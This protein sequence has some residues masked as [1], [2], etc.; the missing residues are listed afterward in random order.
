MGVTTTV[1]TSANHNYVIGQNIRLIIPSAYGSF[2]LN[3]QEGF[4]ISIPAV[5]QIELSINSQGFDSFIASPYIATITGATQTTPCVLTCS[6]SFVPGQYV[7]INNVSGMTELNDNAWRVIS[8]NATTLTVDASASIFTAY[9]G[10]GTAELTNHS[11]TQPQTLAIG[12][13][14]S[15][16]INTSGRVQNITYIPGS[17][18]NISPE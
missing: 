16:Q 13:N 4:V 11:N 17:F 18:I 2:Q 8:A 15:G 6:S 9:S 10:G 7:L 14:N 5:N 12:D 1:T 3:E